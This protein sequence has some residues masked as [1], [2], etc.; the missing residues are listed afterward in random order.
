M[1][2]VSNAGMG[3][4]GAATSGAVTP[5]GSPTPPALPPNPSDE[6]E[7]IVTVPSVAPPSSA[8]A[9]SATDCDPVTSGAL[10]V[11]AFLFSDGTTTAEL[12]TTSDQYG[13][14]LEG[15]AAS[16]GDD[17]S[18]WGAGFA[19][20]L[21]IHTDGG[22]TVPF[23]FAA[24]G[25]HAITFTATVQGSRAVR[26]M[27][28]EFNSHNVSKFSSN[29]EDS[30]FIWGSDRTKEAEVTGYY[31]VRAPELDEPALRASA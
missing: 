25:G 24:M 31:G 9:P 13:W 11:S 8:P 26:P 1:P 20:R 4:S 12:R 18:D 19:L 29:H 7:E 21:A 2:D 30:A 10:P 14:C 22:E 6:G 15:M 16:A 28:T 17:Y 3:S 23:N 27:V 5:V